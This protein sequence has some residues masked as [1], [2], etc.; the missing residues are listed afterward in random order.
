MITTTELTLRGLLHK[1]RIPG[2]VVTITNKYWPEAYVEEIRKSPWLRVFTDRGVIVI[3][4]R[5]RVIEIDWRD[6]AFGVEGHDVVVGEA[7]HGAAYC[8]A[9]SYDDALVCLERLWGAG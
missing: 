1:A 4:W 5:K 8:H 7:T 2:S 6:G 3:G 9:W